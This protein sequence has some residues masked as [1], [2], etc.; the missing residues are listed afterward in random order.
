MAIHKRQ[1]YLGFLARVSF[2]FIADEIDQRFSLFFL[3]RRGKDFVIE[4]KVLVVED[5]L[6]HGHSTELRRGQVARN[7]N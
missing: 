1:T 4:P 5:V 3:G 7:Q 6:F 2:D